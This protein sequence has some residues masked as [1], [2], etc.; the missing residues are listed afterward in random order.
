MTA[1]FSARFPQRPN[2]RIAREKELPRPTKEVAQ[3]EAGE[4]TAGSDAESKTET[5][6]EKTAEA[7]GSETASGTEQADTATTDEPD[8]APVEVIVSAFVQE[9]LDKNTAKRKE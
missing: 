6:G 4:E 8:Q 5:D 1:S 2:T 3:E 7:T 9:Q